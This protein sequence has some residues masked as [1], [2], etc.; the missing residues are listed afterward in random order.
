M[1]KLLSALLFL[2]LFCA[3][4][5]N[6]GFSVS[7]PSETAGQRVVRVGIPLPQGTCRDTAKFGVFSGKQQLPAQFAVLSRYPD[8]SLRWVSADFKAPLNGRALQKFS[9]D[10]AAGKTLSAGDISLRETPDSYF[11]DSGKGK[12]VIGRKKFFFSP[13]NGNSLELYFRNADGELFTAS[14]GV[15]ESSKI[16][17]NGKLRTSFRLE[18]WFASASGEKFC[19][20]ILYLD[21]TSGSSTVK[22]AFSFII[23]GEKDK[24]RGV[25]RR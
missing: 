10:T 6:V 7:N 2:A 22:T 20:Y 11:I 18:G 3:H 9:L 8:N 21:F 14:N 13:A 25:Y 1:K 12:F 15:L 24:A 23:T 5:V 17:A 16:T 4:A 19:R